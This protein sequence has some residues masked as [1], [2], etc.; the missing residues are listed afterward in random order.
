MVV[1]CGLVGEVWERTYYIN[2]RF[3]NL[4]HTGLT[5]VLSFLSIFLG[6]VAQTYI[7][8]PVLTT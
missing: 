8:I 3:N 7:L 5:Y 6:Y 2:L 4:G 1:V